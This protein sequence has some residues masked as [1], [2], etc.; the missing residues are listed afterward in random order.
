M[1]SIAITPE[2]ILAGETDY[3][4]RILEAGWSRVHMRHPSASLGDMRRLLGSLPS[5]CHPRIWIHG[6][7]ELAKEYTLGGIH[8]NSRY[9]QP[10]DGYRGSLSKSC[11]SIDEVKSSRK[12]GIDTVT[13]SPIFDSISKSGYHG[14]FS[15]EDLSQLSP[16]D[17]V[18]ALGGITP[19]RLEELKPYHFSGFAALGYLFQTRSIKDFK[20]RLSNFKP[21]VCYNS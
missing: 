1:I 12:A 6:H 16:E 13:L 4:R 20:D 10:P 17:N 2:D 3:I 5:D 7:H 15:N 11:H 9:P 21:Y 14:A 19:A 18:I 8:L